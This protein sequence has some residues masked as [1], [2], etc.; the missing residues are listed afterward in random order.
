MGKLFYTGDIGFDMSDWEGEEIR[1]VSAGT[2]C[3]A[4]VT[5]DGRALMKWREPDSFRPP[6][7][8]LFDTDPLR[9][10][11][12]THPLPWEGTRQIA[13][14]GI[15]PGMVIGL[16]DRGTCEVSGR[17]TGDIRARVAMWRDIVQVAASDAFFG[18]D[19]SGRVRFEPIWTEFP[20]D[21]AETA[22]WRDVKR[23]AVGRM[24]SVFGITSGGRILRAGA[25]LKRGPNW[26]AYGILR[27]FEGAADIAAAGPYC[28]KIYIAREDGSIAEYAG[29]L[30]ELP[31]RAKVCP[32]GAVLESHW[33]QG[34][35]FRTPE[36]GIGRYTTEGE[37]L[38]VIRAGERIQSFAAGMLTAGSEG[39]LIG[40]SC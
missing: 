17:Y 27:G 2:G 38:P 3:A 25:N 1:S 14:S 19:S 32:G 9:R 6:F 33:E 8:Y 12:G 20:E 22:G 34:L 30:K 26:D 36:G 23:I 7:G 15:F 40:V 24:N 16:T 35:Y 39:F 5:E 10:R 11:R 21:Y 18:L 4:A 31:I 28:E 37:I 13:L 29:R